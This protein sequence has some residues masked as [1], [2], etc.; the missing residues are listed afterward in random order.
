MLR[1]REAAAQIPPPQAGTDALAKTEE[2]FFDSQRREA[3]LQ[4][5]RQD[6]EQRK[7]FANRIFI[8]IAIWLVAIFIVLLLVGFLGEG[9]KI[10]G[11]CFGKEFVFAPKFKLSDAVIIALIGGT[12]VNVL[13]ILILVVQYLFPKRTVK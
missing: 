12:T 3:E 7:S 5:F 1:C 11:T 9:A 4:S 8:L 10:S 13:G 6:T 2:V